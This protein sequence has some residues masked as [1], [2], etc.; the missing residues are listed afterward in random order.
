VSGL[1]VSVCIK[2]VLPIAYECAGDQKQRIASATLSGMAFMGSTFVLFAY[3]GVEE[4]LP[5]LL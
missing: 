2:E 1:I 5:N 3:F 4:D